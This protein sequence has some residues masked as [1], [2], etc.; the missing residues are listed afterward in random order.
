[1]TNMNVV[2]NLQNPGIITN[3]LEKRLYNNEKAMVTHTLV[4]PDFQIAV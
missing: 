3:P 2:V 1:M 4:T